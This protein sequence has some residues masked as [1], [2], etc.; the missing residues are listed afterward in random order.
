MYN[1]PAKRVENALL[2]KTLNL[3]TG[4]M[5]SYGPE[6]AKVTR[7]QVNKAMAGFLKPEKMAITVVGTA[8]ELKESLAKAAGVPVDQVVVK[9]YAQE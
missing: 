4:F 6:I 7:D 2:E 9:P 8:S 5:K 3:P 1:T